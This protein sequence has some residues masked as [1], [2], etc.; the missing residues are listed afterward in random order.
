M[1]LID[2]ETMAQAAAQLRLLDPNI[3]VYGVSSHAILSCFEVHDLKSA[4]ALCSV[5]R[6]A[7]S[8]FLFFFC[9]LGA[10]VWG[11][12]AYPVDRERDAEGFR[13]WCI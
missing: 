10:M 8:F 7:N 9:G 5:R 1:G 11:R 2:V 12:H 13:V 3:I 6:G 4:I